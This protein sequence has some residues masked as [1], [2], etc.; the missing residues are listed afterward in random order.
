MKEIFCF[1]LIIRNQWTYIMHFKRKITLYLVFNIVLME[2]CIASYRRPERF[3]K[4]TRSSL[5]SKFYQGW[6][7]CTTMEFC[8]EISSWRIFCLIRMEILKLQT[9]DFRS[10]N[11]QRK[12]SHT[13]TV[14]VLS[15]WLRKCLQSSIYL[16]QVWSFFPS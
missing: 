7:T 4:K 1:L 10:L 15:I 11:W 9:L 6:N 14:E 16:I 8:F 5:L 3:P 13:L 12:I 2:I